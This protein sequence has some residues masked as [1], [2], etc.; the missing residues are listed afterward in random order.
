MRSMG[1][2]KGA[3]WLGLALL[4]L[5][6]M[7]PALALSQ[8]A[9][10]P[11]LGV[12]LQSLNDGLRD[13]MNYDGQ[14]VVVS[15]VVADSP[16]DRAGIRKG[17]VIAR[18]E[19][20]SVD[21]PSEVTRIVREARVGETI[22]LV[23]YRDGSRRTV[24]ARLGSWPDRADLEIAPEDTPTPSPRVRVEGPDGEWFDRKDS[25]HEDR[26]AERHEERKETKEGKDLSEEEREDLE[27]KLDGRKD[28]E[29]LDRLKDL[30]K[31]EGFQRM[32]GGNGSGLMWNMGRGR[33]GVRAENLS[34]D[35]AP[36]FEAPDGGA[37][38]MEVLKDTPADRAGLKA[39]DVI[40][41]VNDERISDAEDLVRTLRE[42]PEGRTSVTV[43]RKGER[44]TFEPVLEASPWRAGRS[45]RSFGP[46]ERRMIV[47]DRNGTRV[48]GPDATDR[49]REL[50][51]LREEVKRLRERLEERNRG[52]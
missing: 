26:H 8:S 23:V 5:C 47:R 11:W 33:L 49:D 19:G 30:D 27:S 31:L 44:R 32:D 7:T 36:Y 21:S 1:R 25:R 6:I 39:G 46:G 13:G 52:D 3:G 14:G 48:Y 51:A 37:L 22:S 20:R 24:S 17:D 38:V 28:L 43:F 10:T 50:E 15:R 40:V 18:V 29:K 42:A 12:S 41:R 9:D 16:A 35:L 34:S 4:A 2:T 45:F